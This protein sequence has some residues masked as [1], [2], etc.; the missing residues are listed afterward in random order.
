MIFAKATLDCALESIAFKYRDSTAIVFEENVV[1]YNEL[2]RF[3]N[4]LANAFYH[5]GVKKNDKVAIILPNCIEYLYVYFSLFMLGAWA[6]PFSTRWTSQEIKNVLK[7]SDTRFIV[8]RDRIGSFDYNDIIDKV[9][10]DGH[11]FVKR[12]VLGYSSV[13]GV[14]RLED[15]LKDGDDMA[16]FRRNNEEND[17]A[18]LAYTS[19]T[20]GVPKG[21]MIPHGTLV[22]SS[23]HTGKLWAKGDEITFSVAPLYAAQGF[24]AVLI[25]LVSGIT[26]KWFSGF[27]PNDILY[28]LSKKDSNVFHTQPTMWN[29]LL[30]LSYINSMNFS[31]L[32]KVVVSGS[33]CSSHLAE[34]IENTMGCKVLNAYGLIE[35]T[36]VVTVTRES[37]TKDIRFNTVGR[38]IEG[39]EVKIVNDE[40]KEVTRGEIGELAVRGYLMKG[41]YK[42][43]EKTDEIIDEEGW[44]YT[45]DLARFYD[46]ENIS[47]VGRKKDMIIRGG[48]NVY[49]VDIEDCIAR[50]EKVE[51][52]SVV[53]T[54]HD[55]FGESINAFVVPKPGE[56]ISAGDVIRYCRDKIANY[57]IP[58]EVILVSQLPTLLSGKVQKNVLK[59]WLREGIPPDCTVLFNGERAG[60]SGISKLE[61]Q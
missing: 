48:F 27:N 29:M 18:L 44:L 23:F 21:V 34:R 46:E 16:V 50:N 15:L 57:K 5:L 25:D 39:V 60:L 26:M 7:D 43:Q 28:E 40:R 12:I 55:I 9:E 54:E 14:E 41:Y 58:D 2:I 42:Q 33:L 32:K 35:A 6:V 52:V 37:D 10:S 47:I 61:E 13:K 59:Q 49:P 22:R 30:S 36:G 38:P 1:S 17:V 11:S 24:L 53:G 31:N 4:R 45:G 20:T 8:Y 51:S 56:N 3:S 19:G